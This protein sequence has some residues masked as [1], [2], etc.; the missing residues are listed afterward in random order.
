M[1]FLIVSIVLLLF[2]ISRLIFISLG[3]VLSPFIF[4]LAALPR[5]SDF[6]YIA[7]K[8][9]V[10]SIFVVFVHVVIIQLAGSFLTLPEHSENSLISIAIG[11]GLFI[12]LLKTPSLMMQMIYYTSNN[13]TFKKLG[14]QIINVMSTDNSA[15]ATRAAAQN[16]AV[17]TPRKVIKV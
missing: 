8:T 13:G 2:Y 12:T 9:Y 11:I 14:T 3:A 4:L 1:L 10:A 17:K 6:A 7:S 5:F 15:S 16:V